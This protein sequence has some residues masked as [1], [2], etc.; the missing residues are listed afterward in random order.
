M[1][2]VALLNSVDNTQKGES[3]MTA[4]LSFLQYENDAISK[5]IYI[6]HSYIVT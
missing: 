3:I 4:C 6:V 1:L 5:V 2:F